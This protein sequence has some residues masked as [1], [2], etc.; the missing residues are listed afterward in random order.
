[1]LFAGSIEAQNLIAVQNGGEPEFYSKLDSAI[2]YSSTGDTIYIPGGNYTINDT[3]T[4]RLHLVGSG[5]HPDSAIATARTIISGFTQLIL[6]NGADNGSVTGIYFNEPGQ[7]AYPPIQILDPISSYTISSCYI[8]KS[9]ENQGNN[10]TISENIFYNLYSSGINLYC[11]NNIILGYVTCNSGVIKNNVFTH[12]FPGYSQYSLYVGNNIVENNIFKPYTV[13]TGVGT[14]I[15]YHNVNGGVN[16]IIGQEQG[17]G[18]FLD[19]VELPLLFA[20]YSPET[21]YGDG[22][23]DADFHLPTNSPYKNA[24]TDGTDIGIYGGPFPWKEG[25]VPFN[26]HIQHKIISGGTDQNGNLNVNI[27]VAAQ[28]Y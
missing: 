16:G 7:Y 1:M 23:Y 14:S 5:H 26:P 8:S 15:F 28:D 27:K 3:I 21:F 9:I 6:K 11:T 13:Q 10:T 19:N 24:G 20:N 17:S 12:R 22:I 4:K 2:F 25:S 18:N